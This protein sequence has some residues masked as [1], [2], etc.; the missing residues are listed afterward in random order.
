MAMRAPFGAL[1]TVDL[2]AGYSI[3]ALRDETELPARSWLSWR[4]FHPDEPDSAFE[5]W[6][7][8][9]NIQRPAVPPR[10]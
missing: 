1:P 6:D 3:R 7:W 2:P 4:A 9:R 10:A 5:G 8:Y